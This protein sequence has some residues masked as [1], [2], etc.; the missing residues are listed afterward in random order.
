MRG[1]VYVFFN[2]FKETKQGEQKKGKSTIIRRDK[3]K[4]FKF[5]FKK[6]H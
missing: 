5:K 3:K 6:G 4:T 2:I 1:N